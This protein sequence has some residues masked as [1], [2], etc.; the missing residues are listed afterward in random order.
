MLDSI[1]AG[2]LQQE[3]NKMSKE[4]KWMEMGN[5][6]GPDLIKHFAVIGEPDT[7]ASQIKSRYGDLIDRSCASY[8]NIAKSDQLKIIKEKVVN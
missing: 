1:G 4:G 2:E 5:L 6:I 7:I 8:A 3:L